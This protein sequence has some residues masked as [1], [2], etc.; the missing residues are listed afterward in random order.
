MPKKNQSPE[1]MNRDN[2]VK[3][4]NKIISLYQQAT[5][6][7]SKFIAYVLAKIRMDDTEILSFETT[8]VE[9]CAVAG[10]DRAY[11]V[12][13]IK[14]FCDTM[15]KVGVVV[16]KGNDAFD[17][18]TILPTFQYTSGRLRIS[19]NPDL[20]PYLLELKRGESTSYRLDI[21]RAMRSEY[22]IKLF[23]YFKNLYSQPGSKADF[24][25]FE[26]VQFRERFLDKK[27]YR[28][29]NYIGN[30]E[31]RVIKPAIDEIN[32]YS[33]LSMTYSKVRRGRGVLFVFTVEKNDTPWWVRAEKAAVKK[34]LRRSSDVAQLRA[35]PRR[36]LIEQLKKKTSM[37]AEMFDGLT[38]EFSDQGI[39]IIQ[40]ENVFL[41][42]LRELHDDDLSTIAK[43]HLVEYRD[44]AELPL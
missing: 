39:I 24:Y 16:D 43:P 30:I 3:Y 9:A 42:R 35:D 11:T 1:V 33:D 29:K 8:Y 2:L 18:M 22:A 28:D 7:Q 23:E 36:Y 6:A 4:D 21:I 19:V 37:A 34:S 5:K 38:V 10:I 26:P 27:E 14:A 20:K 40:G 13:E 44:I 41:R 32:A 31:N 17:M 15:R 12:S 25:E